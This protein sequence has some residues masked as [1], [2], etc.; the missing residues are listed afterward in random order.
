[1]AEEQF[2]EKTEAPSP[3]R[4]EEAIKE[5]RF[6]ESPDLAS[7]LELLLGL[8]ALSY[9]GAQ[10]INAQMG[11]FRSTLGEALRF[12]DFIHIERITPA[13][14]QLAIPAAAGAVLIAAGAVLGGV[15]QVGLHLNLS[16]LEPKWE[17]ISPLTNLK[18]IFSVESLVALLLGTLKLALIG[19]CAYG[20]LAHVANEAPRFWEY[21]VRVLAAKG[22]TL[23]FELGWRLAAMLFGLALVD[24]G[25]KRWQHEKSLRMTREEAKEELKQQEGDP[26]IKQRIRQ[27]QRQRAARRMMSDVPKASVVIA[28]P[29]HVAIALQYEPGTHR[30]PVVLA[31]GEHLVAQRIKALAAEH[32]IPVM[33]EPPLA[34]ALLRAVEVGQEIPV[35]FYRAVAEILAQLYKR[36]GNAVRRLA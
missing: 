33:E 7:A 18:Q 1:M 34:R 11:L 17:R 22:G 24:Y 14:H 16:W 3:R 2:G 15:G 19:W 4:L 32:G 30:A 5:G 21:P 6:A 25:W 28:N 27:L 9:F 29:T 10:L 36:R 12:T 8:G 26:K 20:F 31:K 13:L 35:E 23:L